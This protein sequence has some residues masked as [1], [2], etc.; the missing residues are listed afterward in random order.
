VSYHCVF[1]FAWTSDDQAGGSRGVSTQATL[2]L[3]P[4]R[5]NRYLWWQIGM[6]HS[7]SMRPCM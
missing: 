6:R 3:N 1:N 5:L 4:W 7:R 2:E